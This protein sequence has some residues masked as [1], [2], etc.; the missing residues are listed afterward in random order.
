M[1]ADELQQK[2]GRVIRHHREMC[3]Y[4]QEGFANEIA[5][6]RAYY[7]TVERGK[8][9]ITLKTL[10]QIATGLDAAP[11]QLLH[12]AESWNESNFPALRRAGRPRK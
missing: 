1:T 12:Q 5:I 2:L 11:S 10:H 9:N 8:Q 4:S 3:G 6:P 7:G